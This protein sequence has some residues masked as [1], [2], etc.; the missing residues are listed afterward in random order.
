MRR[1]R[2]GPPVLTQRGLN[3]ALLARQMLLVRARMPIEPAVSH[4]VGLQAQR[5]D[6]PHVGLWS[7]IAGLDHRQTDELLSICPQPACAR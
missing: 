6:P 7:R 5:P 4:L 1:L 2:G 3:R